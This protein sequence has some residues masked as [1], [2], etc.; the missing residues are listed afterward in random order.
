[1][2]CSFI[3]VGFFFFFWST[4]KGLDIKPQQNRAILF[5]FVKTIGREEKE[6]R[7]VQR[8]CLLSVVAAVIGGG[9][10]E[11]LQGSARGAVF[12]RRVGRAEDRSDVMMELSSPMESCV[13]H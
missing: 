12:R 11:P 9:M 5:D 4:Q 8:I 13:L 7:R 6:R 3:F 1:M 2:R 10:G